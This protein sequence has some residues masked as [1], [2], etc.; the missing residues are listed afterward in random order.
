MRAALAV[1]QHTLPDTPRVCPGTVWGPWKEA[2]PPDPL[3]IPLSDEEFHLFQRQIHQDVGIYLSPAK[4]ALVAGRLWKRLRHYGFGS[5]RDYF[6]F[7]TQ[8]P[9]RDMGEYEVMIDLISTNETHFFREPHHF[10]FLAETVLPQWSA[11]AGTPFRVWS[12]ACSSGEEAYSLAITL[13][14]HFGGG[15][16][17]RYEVL[18]TDINQTVLQ[19]AQMAIYPVS[20]IHEIP[21]AYLCKYFLKGVRRQ[22]GTIRVDPLIRQKVRFQRVNLNEP[23]PRMPAFDAIFCRNVLIYFDGETK[24]RVVARLLGVLKPGGYFFVGHS[25]SLNGVTDAVQP[26]VPTVYRKTG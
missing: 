8:G 7:A 21:Q 9:G 18:A 22:A 4:K 24:R 2:Q 23:L 15:E 6:L 1:F 26:V 5:Y 19:K 11:P 17:G 13:A 12:A 16:P 25:E 20:Q 3:A 14:E 10:R